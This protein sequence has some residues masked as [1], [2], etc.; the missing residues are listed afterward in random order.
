MYSALYIGRYDPVCIRE[1]QTWYQC[2]S[3]QHSCHYGIEGFYSQSI[4]VPNAVIQLLSR[5][6]VDLTEQS[7]FIN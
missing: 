2:Q 3:S 1:G 5:M 4:Y 6:G 7:S